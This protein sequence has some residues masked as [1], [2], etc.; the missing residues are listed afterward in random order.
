MLNNISIGRKLGLLS[1]VYVVPAAFLAWL[2]IVQSGKDIDFAAKERDGNLYM[3]GLRALLVELTTGADHQR[4]QAAG[5]TV[6]A[7]E[8]R[9]GTAMGSTEVHAQLGQALAGTGDAIAATRALIARIGDGSNLI[10][11]PDLDSYYTMDVVVGKLPDFADSSAKVLET[12]RRVASQGDSVPLADAA[13]LL[14]RIGAYGAALD[15][16]EASLEAGYRGN[17]DNSL[18]AALDAPFKSYK[19]AA[20]AYAETLQALAPGATAARHP[21]AAALNAAQQTAMNAADVFWQAALV[22]LD[23]LLAARIAGLR[24]TLAGNLAAALAVVLAA[25]ALAFGISRSVSRPLRALDAAMM[26]LAGGDRGIEIPHSDR[27]DEVGKMATSLRVFKEGLIEADH[28]AEAARTEQER[29][30]ARARHMQDLAAAFETEIDGTLEAVGSAAAR[31]LGT[32][33]GMSDTARDAGARANDVAM[34]AEQTSTS[35]QAVA[36]AA[37]ELS[38]SIGEIVRQVGDATDV[39]VTA[40]KQAETANDIVN[41]LTS[42]AERIGEVVT[43]IN[44]IAGQTNLLA[45]NATI[46]AARAGEAGKGFAVVANEVKNLA[47]QTG[48]ATADI[49]QQVQGVQ[50][51]TEHAVGAILSIQQIIT[52]IS[53]ISANIA[54][55]VEQQGIATQEIA[56]NA[57]RAAMATADVSGTAGDVNQA[58][59]RTGEAASE[60]S[61]ASNTLSA[62]A[63]DL[64]QC[65]Q[66][67]LDQIKAA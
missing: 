24:A 5:A 40:V 41:G 11:D 39:A 36:S 17:A 56:R 59:A 32:S 57:E 43:L 51:A 64:R 20:Q 2:L 3:G 42:A 45:L 19:A 14:T 26:R 67:F 7:L 58:A 54:D 60:V 46:E 47:S 6:A 37:E 21:D 1:F 25:L 28:L 38:A 35:V 13:E 16:A 53:D 27:R 44:D 66:R 65:V 4:Q 8:G 18:K 10:L 48:R 61:D 63:E 33:G 34:A 31:L 52:H 62:E 22:E 9:F 49:A 23:R 12:A 55:A 30:M 50:A 15:G 29:R